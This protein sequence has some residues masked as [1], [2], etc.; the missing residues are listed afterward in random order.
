MDAF[1]VFAPSIMEREDYTDIDVGADYKINIAGLY[2]M[3][4]DET[5]AYEKT[6][7]K[8]LLASTDYD[9]IA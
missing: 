1:F 2:P 6:G 3:Y 8:R 4:A 9:N 7:L 5:E